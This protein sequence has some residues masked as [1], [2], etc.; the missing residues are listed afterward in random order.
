[1]FFTVFWFAVSPASWFW[2]QPLQDT[3]AGEGGRPRDVENYITSLL[4]EIPP[5]KLAPVPSQGGSKETN[6]KM[7]VFAKGKCFSRAFVVI[8][9]TDLDQS[10]SCR[11]A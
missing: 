4:R 5:V 8:R 7:A 9:R 1:M 2:R 6:T 10:C 11:R 3:K